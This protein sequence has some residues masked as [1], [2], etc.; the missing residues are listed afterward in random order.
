MDLLDKWDLARSDFNADYISISYTAI[1]PRLQATSYFPW[2]KRH[3]LEPQIVQTTV[4][5]RYNAVQYIMLSQT[6][7]QWQQQ[8]INLILNSQKPPHSS[9]SQ[10]SYGVS[11]MNILEKI[12]H[13]IIAP[14]LMIFMDEIKS[15]LTLRLEWCL[16]IDGLVQDCSISSASAMEILQ[17]CTK[18]SKWYILD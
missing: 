14:L 16:Y 4:C 13:V 11:V 7:L 5:C 2:A 18:P 1:T 10:V 9:P 8:N 6:V 12:D 15:N 17:P 3:F